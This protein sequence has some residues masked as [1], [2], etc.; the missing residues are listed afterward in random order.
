MPY[1]MVSQP[2]AA[3]PFL[4]MDPAITGFKHST[5]MFTGLL[6]L[7]QAESILSMGEHLL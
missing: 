5:E 4:Y 2:T 1:L 6:P 3:L 7:R